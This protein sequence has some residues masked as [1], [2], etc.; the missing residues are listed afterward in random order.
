MKFLSPKSWLVAAALL[1]GF[2]TY[3]DAQILRVDLKQMVANTDGAVFGTITA[4]ETIRIDHPIDGPELYFTTLT[5]EGKSLETGAPTT[6]S[7]SFPGGFI[8]EEQ[9]VYNSEAPEADVI[10]IGKQVVAFHLWSDN[11]G[12]DFA[13]N[14][15]YASHGGIYPTFEDARGQVIVQGRGDGYAIPSN[16]YLSKLTQDIRQFDAKQPR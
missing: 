12:G 8:N 6:V 13:S 3:G 7:M 10:K 2:G 11:M 5:I 4:K 16:T 9:G 15:L 14:V 1:A